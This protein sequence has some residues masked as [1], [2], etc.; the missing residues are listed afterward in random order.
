MSQPSSS[1]VF[2]R[3]PRGEV[4]KKIKKAAKQRTDPAFTTSFKGASSG[5]FWEMQ[6]RLKAMRGRPRKR[7]A[8]N[9]VER[10]V[11]NALAI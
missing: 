8:Q 9:Q 3:K 1:Y 10:V 6:L 2:L 11:L 7:S 4:L 5:R